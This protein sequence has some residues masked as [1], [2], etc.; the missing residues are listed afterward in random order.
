MSL[1]CLFMAVSQNRALLQL[2]RVLMRNR[3]P[4]S[5]ALKL[6]LMGGKQIGG[7]GI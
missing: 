7:L 4:S 3:A 2:W 5:S 1:W 6:A